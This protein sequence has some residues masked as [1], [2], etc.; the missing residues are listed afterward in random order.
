[1][2]SIIN[3]VLEYFL[4]VFYLSEIVSSCPT[5]SPMVDRRLSGDGVSRSPSAL[6]L[7]LSFGCQV[8]LARFLFTPTTTPTITKTSTTAVG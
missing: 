6:L 4:N 3:G 5:G 1:M 2:K 7:R 8:P